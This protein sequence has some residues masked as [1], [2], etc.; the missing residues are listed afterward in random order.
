MCPPAQAS[1]VARMPDNIPCFS[2]KFNGK[3]RMRV[4]LLKALCILAVIFVGVGL[5]G[6]AIRR[7]RGL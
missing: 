5:L 6:L 3:S 4:M 2:Y 1:T 7:R